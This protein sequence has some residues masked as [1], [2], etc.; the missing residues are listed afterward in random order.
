MSITIIAD[1]IDN[2]EDQAISFKDA[3]TNTKHDF[4]HFLNDV[5]DFLLSENYNSNT[6]AP[7]DMITQ[8]SAP[9][10]LN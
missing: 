5:D 4:E 10:P 9:I 3:I 7:N 2:G 8:Q 6:T 1:D